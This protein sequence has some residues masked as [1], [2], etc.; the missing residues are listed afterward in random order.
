MAEI[1]V[2]AAGKKPGARRAKRLSTRVDLTPMVDLGFLLITFFIFSARLSEPKALRLHT[3][4][5]FTDSTTVGAQN[6]LTVIPLSSKSILHYHGEWQEAL[7]SKA[8]SITSWSVSG[9]IGDVIREKKAALAS[10]KKGDG[11]ELMLL[12]KP[13]NETSYQDLV[14]LLDE[15][16]INDISRYAITDITEE[17]RQFIATNG[18]LF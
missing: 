2:A 5:P 17:E 9:G 3:P 7:A 12:I 8:W 18:A 1:T 13:G 6:A 11:K 4:K 10:K 14:N 16:L 15:V